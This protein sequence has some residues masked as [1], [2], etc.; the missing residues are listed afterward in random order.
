MIAGQFQSQG[1][2]EERKYLGV[3]FIFG[4]SEVTLMVLRAW[5]VKIRADFG[6]AQNIQHLHGVF[7][8]TELLELAGVFG[9]KRDRGLVKLGRPL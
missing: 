8:R 4:I 2:K 3:G 1:E 6:S 7:A 9:R 5:L